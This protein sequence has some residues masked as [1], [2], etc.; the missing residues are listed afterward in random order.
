MNYMPAP[1]YK[2]FT[3]VLWL[4]LWD[5]WETI[6]LGVYMVAYHELYAGANEQVQPC[7]NIPTLEFACV[8]KCVALTHFNEPMDSSFL[9]RIRTF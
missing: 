8:L 9:I 5:R 4:F 1:A 2:G 3:G 6:W 7:K